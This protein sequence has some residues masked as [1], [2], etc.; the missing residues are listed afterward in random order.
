[1][2]LLLTEMYTWYSGSK[3]SSYVVKR[4]IIWILKVIKTSY[5]LKKENLIKREVK[6]C[7]HI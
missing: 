6:K 1:M 3:I 5:K 2:I 7:E 4:N